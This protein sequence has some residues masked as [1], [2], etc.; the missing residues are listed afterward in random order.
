MVLEMARRLGR[1]P[2]PCPAGSY[3][4][5]LQRRGEGVAGLAPNYVANPLYPVAKTVF[6]VNFDMV[7]RLNEQDELTLF[8]TG[9]TPGAP[10]STK[11]TRR[12]RVGRFKIKKVKRGSPAASA[13]ATT[14]RSTWPA[15]Q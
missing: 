7:G 12:R 11:S 3:L 5:G 15:S 1:R 10:P 2:D 4:L 8:G 14:S 6:M 9:S 13:A